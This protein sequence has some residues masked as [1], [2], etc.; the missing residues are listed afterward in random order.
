MRVSFLIGW[1]KWFS[2]DFWEFIGF[3]SGCLL[4]ISIL[5]LIVTSVFIFIEKSNEIRRV[6]GD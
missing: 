5:G 4:C 2:A 6:K 1:H 3:A